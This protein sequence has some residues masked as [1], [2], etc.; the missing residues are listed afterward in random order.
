MHAYILTD[1]VQPRLFYKLLYDSLSHSFF[2]TNC[3]KHRYQHRA[4]EFF[5]LENIHPTPSDRLKKICNFYLSYNKILDKVVELVGGGSVINGAYP[6][7][8]D[9]FL[10]KKKCQLPEYS[11]PN[12]VRQLEFCIFSNRVCQIL[13]GEI[14]ALLTICTF[15]ISFENF[16]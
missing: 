16:I 11:D 8:F 4:R 13:P 14:G 1:P 6:V 3:S 2:S 10:N 7:Q 15:Q 5:F 12:T 9:L